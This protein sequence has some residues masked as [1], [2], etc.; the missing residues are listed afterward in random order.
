MGN[1]EVK[2]NLC[3]W[4][5]TIYKRLELY[6]SGIYWIELGIYLLGKPI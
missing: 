3:C 5:G 1:F 4:A 2:Y 6:F